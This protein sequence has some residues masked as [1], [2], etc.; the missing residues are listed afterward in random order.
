M[1]KGQSLTIS[2]VV[3]L[4]VLVVSFIAIFLVVYPNIKGTE[5]IVKND[6]EDEL[7]NTITMPKEGTKTPSNPENPKLFIIEDECGLINGNIIN[8]ISDNQD[9]RILCRNK[10]SVMNM[11]FDRSEIKIQEDECNICNCYCK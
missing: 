7:V 9:C 2:I 1:K 6:N 3:I 10:C 4:L 8:T 11:S 5:D